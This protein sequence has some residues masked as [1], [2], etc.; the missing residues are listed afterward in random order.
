MHL[1]STLDFSIEV[2]FR[3]LLGALL[4]V[5]LV[6]STGGCSN[7]VSTQ[8]DTDLQSTALENRADVEE[9]L[10]SS[11]DEKLAFALALE[12]KGADASEFECDVLRALVEDPV[13]GLVTRTAT[14]ALG[15]GDCADEESIGVLVES[16]KSNDFLC[17]ESAALALGEIGAESAVEPL[18]SLLESETYSDKQAAQHALTA[19]GPVAVPALVPLLISSDPS[20][21]DRAHAICRSYGADAI[22]ELRRSGELVSDP[23]LEQ[24]I[25]DLVSGLQ[26]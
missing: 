11:S 3:I 19:I 26:E 8:S 2:A 1:T 16:L 14:A 17:R 13:S 5:L 9:I 6:R 10:K 7:S 4:L 25:S 24:A 22:P 23:T 15:K 12:D 20:T 18:A 21:K